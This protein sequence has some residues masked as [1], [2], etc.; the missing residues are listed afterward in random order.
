MDAD[1][2]SLRGF[3][4]SDAG[5]MTASGIAFSPDGVVDRLDAAVAFVRALG[6]DGEARDLAGTTVTVDGTPLVDNDAIPDSLRGHVQISLDTGIQEAFPAE[7]IEVAP[8]EFQAVPGPRFE[9]D[10]EVTRAGLAVTLDRFA[11]VFDAGPQG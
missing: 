4:F 9:P 8:G 5:M 10:T 3:D 2:S 11:P 6:R 1:G 7:I